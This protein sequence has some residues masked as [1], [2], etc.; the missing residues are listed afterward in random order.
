MA[1]LG[2]V[3]V[4]IGCFSLF[5]SMVKDSTREIAVRSALG[6]GPR[7]LAAQM[8]LRALALGLIGSIAGVGGSMAVGAAV[9]DQLFQVDSSSATALG[10]VALG[11]LLVVVVASYCPIRAA[12]R[13]DPAP[14]L[15]YE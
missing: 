15:K 1:V 11:V 9:A 8:T 5:A 2:I 14:A 7:R 4:A 13:R 6:A 10:T 12:V 3:V